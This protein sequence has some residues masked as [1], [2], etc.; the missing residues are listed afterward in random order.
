MGDVIRRIKAWFLDDGL[1]HDWDGEWTDEDLEGA[2]RHLDEVA[3][4]SP[5]ILRWLF[6]QP[7]SQSKP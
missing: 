2:R 3:T 1:N 5:D 4:R 7:S 6:T